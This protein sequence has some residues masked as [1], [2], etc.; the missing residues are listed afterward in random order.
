MVPLSAD[1][2]TYST[3]RDWEQIVNN[4]EEDKGKTVL[5]QVLRFSERAVLYSKL[6]SKMLFNW[7]RI[8]T[9]SWAHTMWVKHRG[10]LN[11]ARC[12]PIP[13]S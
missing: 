11:K 13:M 12:H 4:Q 10:P 8:L 5:S 1:S 6:L 2:G 7:I 9:N 3:L